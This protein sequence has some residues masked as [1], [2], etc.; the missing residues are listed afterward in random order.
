MNVTCRSI[1]WLFNST[2][3][4]GHL[5]VLYELA[6]LEGKTERRLNSH[7][8]LKSWGTTSQTARSCACR[9]E[10][11]G[12][13]LRWL[14]NQSRRSSDSDNQPLQSFLVMWKRSGCSVK[15]LHFFNHYNS[16]YHA[17]LSD[18]NIDTLSRQTKQQLVRIG[19]FLL[20]CNIYR[21]TSRV[22]RGFGLLNMR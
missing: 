11:S 18:R 4:G 6:V 5:G 22:V 1:R 20:A 8:T 7:S 2:W 13:W 21:R 16:G 17:F 12:T 3:C 19:W 10:G 14:V 15:Y 9:E